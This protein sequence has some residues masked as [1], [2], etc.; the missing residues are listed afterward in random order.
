[1]DPKTCSARAPATVAP[2]VLA[3][4]L[5]VRIAEIG[6]SILSLSLRRVLPERFFSSMSVWIY[7]RVIVRRTASSRE[8]R[9]EM[10]STANTTNEE[11]AHLFRLRS[12]AES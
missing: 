6:S 12:L 1:M 3:I 10:V 7:G 4:V 5:S 11:L 2:T 9:K 8:H